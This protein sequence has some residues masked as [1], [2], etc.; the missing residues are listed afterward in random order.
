[1]KRLTKK[2]K[3][4]K[5]R[6]AR[7]H[8]L[9]WSWFKRINSPQAQPMPILKRR[10]KR[11]RGQTM[12]EYIVLVAIIAVASIPVLTLLGNVFRDRV[13]NAADKMVNN[14]GGYHSEG[15]S[16]VQDGH[17]KVKKNM[18]NFHK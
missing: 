13:M 5:I 7:L 18:G 6:E 16:M 10:K 1:M 9:K 11:N 14:Q 2:Q 15:S 3:Q 12:M 8:L 4:I 17:N